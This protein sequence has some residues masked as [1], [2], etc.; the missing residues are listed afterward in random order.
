[1]EQ[2]AN[3]LETTRAALELAVQQSELAQ[4]NLR[5]GRKAFELGETDLVG[6]LRVQGLAFVAQRNREQRSLE[7]NL[8]VAR[9]NQAAGE[10]P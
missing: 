10:L 7:L 3:R 8:N 4:E 9:Y 6:L 2:A 1:L 5:L